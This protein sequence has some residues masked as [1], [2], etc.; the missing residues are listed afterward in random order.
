MNKEIIDSFLDV[1]FLKNYDF[2]SN[3]VF[4]DN[5]NV[6]IIEFFNVIDKMD[7]LKIDVDSYFGIKRI[8]IKKLIFSR[9]LFFSVK[10]DDF[11]INDIL[12]FKDY[13]VEQRIFRNCIDEILFL[14]EYEYCSD[15][16]EKLKNDYYYLIEDR[17]L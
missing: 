17:Y 11:K 6:K 8:L 15:K 4:I 16:L 3:K 13:F 2:I 5:M 1:E 12:T 9:K 10:S 7:D 14:D